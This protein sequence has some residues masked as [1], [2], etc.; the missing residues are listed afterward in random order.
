MNVADILR[1]EGVRVTAPWEPS[2][3]PLPLPPVATLASGAS[4]PALLR[5]KARISLPPAELV[6]V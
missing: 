2:P 3:A 1:P 4:R 6:W 5:A